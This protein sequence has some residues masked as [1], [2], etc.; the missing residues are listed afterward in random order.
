[1]DLGEARVRHVGTFLVSSESSH[2]VASH[3][4][5]GEVEN[6]A[7]SAGRENDGSGSVAFDLPGAEVAGHDPLGMTVDQNEVHHFGAGVHFDPALVDLF[8]QRLVAT[9]EQLLAGLAAGVECSADLRPTK[10]TVVAHP[11]ELARE[12]PPLR[13]A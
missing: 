3:R 9:Q 1:M 6:V 13:D 2:D 10:G 11:A 8:F 5:G 7:L 12:G 4:I